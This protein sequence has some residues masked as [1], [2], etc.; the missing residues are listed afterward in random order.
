MKEQ[1]SNDIVAIQFP[2]VVYSIT[3]AALAVLKEKYKTVPDAN[4]P[5]GYKAIQSGLSEMVPIRTALEKARVDKKSEALEYGR[6][7]DGE[8]KRITA[9]LLSIETPYKKAKKEFDD[10]EKDRIEKITS[11]IQSVIEMCELDRFN[12]KDRD[13]E[14]LKNDLCQVNS[15]VPAEFDEFEERMSDVKADAIKNIKISIGLREK[16]DADQ[17]ELDT[18]R[19]E[20]EAR[21][22]ADK[23]AIEVKQRA[24]REERI[25]VEARE[26][27]ENEAKENAARI[28][29]EKQQAIE[30]QK[31]A[32][33]RAIHAE[34]QA[35][36][37]S[38]NAVKAEREKV[39]AQKLAEK[40]AA[41][42]REANTR[43]KKKVNNE[44]VT[45][46][47]A[48]GLDDDMAKKIV[49]AIAKKEIKNVS[50]FY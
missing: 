27:A 38:D 49:T 24:E 36:I 23:A 7:V 43:H 32:E 50:I 29:R 16:Q 4:E 37:D 26:K 12:W 45:S 19:A 47:I 14:L 10:I 2:P 21:D 20:K 31:A 46:L 6:M 34:K 3:D 11:A 48:I 44:A 40:Q 33:Q 1:E 30:A 35:K 9:E 39:E 25:A 13:V 28:E 17:K 15:I 8:A 41:E 18:L 42:K 5:D 22:E